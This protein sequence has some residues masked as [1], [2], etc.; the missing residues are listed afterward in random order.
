MNVIRVMGGLGNQMY[1]YAFGQLQKANGIEVAYDLSWFKNHSKSDIHR[2]YVLDKF[3]TDMKLSKF[4]KQE[5]I[6]EKK[7]SPVLTKKKNCN[8]VGYWQCLDTYFPILP[9][10]QADLRLKEQ[11]YTEKYLKIKK[12]ILKQESISVHIRRGDYLVT[13]GFGVLPFTYYLKAIYDHEGDLF[14]FSDDIQWCRKTFKKEYFV[15]KVTFVNVA[16]YLAFDLM[17]LCKHN[18]VANSSFSCLAAFVN[19]NENKWICAPKRWNNVET[20]RLKEKK[21]HLPKKWIL[22]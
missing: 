1:Q 9:Q 15:G 5:T 11:F 4:L 13:P 20:P 10:L 7:Y 17:R 21:Q 16:D 22:C 12:A 14:I 18:I 6:K 8:F 3:H 2:E 19:P